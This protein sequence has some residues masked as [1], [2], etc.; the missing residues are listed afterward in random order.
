VWCYYYAND[1]TLMCDN[2][3]SGQTNGHSGPDGNGTGVTLATGHGS[4]IP[5]GGTG[6]IY[7]LLNFSNSVHLYTISLSEAQTANNSNGFNFEQVEAVA[8]AGPGAGVTPLYRASNN[9][10]GDFLYTTSYTEASTSNG[11][12]YNGVA[13]YIFTSSASGRCP[14]YRLYDNYN[15]IH[16]YTVSPHEWYAAPSGVNQEGIIGYVSPLSGYSCPN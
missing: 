16:Y 13:F 3:S 12:T 8:P 7:R 4:S 15:V 11:Y 2:D 1:Y 6:A 9:T 14:L 5:N 10:N